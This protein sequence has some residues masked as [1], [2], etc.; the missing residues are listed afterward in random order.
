MGYI[1]EEEGPS[2]EELREIEEL[3]NKEDEDII[4]DWK[5]EIANTRIYYQYDN[6]DAFIAWLKENGIRWQ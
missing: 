1:N 4:D 3:I 2:E 5:E 6:M